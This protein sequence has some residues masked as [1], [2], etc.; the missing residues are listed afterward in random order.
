MPATFSSYPAPTPR[1]PAHPIA[2][3][4]AYIYMLQ[5]DVIALIFTFT[6]NL[7]LFTFT[8]CCGVTP[9]WDLPLFIVISLF[10]GILPFTF[11]QVLLHPVDSPLLLTPH[12]ILYPLLLCE[13]RKTVHL[14]CRRTLSPFTYSH[15][16][17]LS[18]FLPLC[19]LAH[20]PPSHLA[21]LDLQLCLPLQTCPAFCF[22]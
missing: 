3:P 9:A 18:F 4:F 16:Y 19:P 2:G 11:S 13:L 22:S 21:I 5:A 8:Y 20:P 6:H 14:C 12:T 1:F 15:Y 7:L 17:L 10:E